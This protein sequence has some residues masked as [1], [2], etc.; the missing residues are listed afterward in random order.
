METRDW[1]IRGFDP[2]KGP[3]QVRVDTVEDLFNP[4]DPHP[5]HLRD[6]DV[7]IAGWITDWAQEQPGR[8]P[9]SIAVRVADA[10]FEGRESAVSDGIHNHFAYRR[11]DASRRLS[12]LWREGRISLVIGLAVMAVFTTISRLIES[13]S[14]TAFVDLVQEGLAVAPWVAMWR[15]MEIFLYLWWPIRAE[16]RTFD[17]LVESHV[18][19]T[20]SPR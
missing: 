6:L 19:Y 7:E 14:N 12:R 8:V 4:I 10:S 13:P 20:H 18:T 2:S 5:L 16:R 15:P 11:W 3:I 9:V 1:A 17:R